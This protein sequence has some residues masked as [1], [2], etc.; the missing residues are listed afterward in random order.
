MKI[1]IVRG[2]LAAAGGA[3]RYTL[4]LLR[5]LLE[6]DHEVHV[7]TSRLPEEFAGRVQW[8]RFE[9]PRRLIR[10][11]RLWRQRAFEKWM[12]HERSSS[13]LDVWLTLER[14]WP[15]DI[16]RAGDGVH[17]EWL[18]ICRREAGRLRAMQMRWQPFH[19][20]VLASEARVFDARNTQVVVC[21]SQ[22]VAGEI[23]RHYA[24]PAQRVRVVPNGVDLQYFRP[25]AP[26][27]RQR[28]RQERGLQDGELAVLFVG[29]G[30]WRKGVDRALQLL[31]HWQ[32]H[33]TRRLKLWV[34]GKDH[35]QAYQ[36]QAAQLGIAGSV[37]W[38]GALPPSEVLSWYQAAD[39]FLFPTR[40][41]PFANVCLEANACGLPV[42]TTTRNGFAEQMQNGTNGLVL[43][44]AQSPAQQASCIA[45]WSR[46]LPP[47][48]TVRAAVEHLTVEAH[49]AALLETIEECRAQSTSRGNFAL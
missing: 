16:F 11:P 20:R 14:I 1:G 9:R 33:D 39:L 41:D 35:L 17:R 25:A 3:E 13:T 31:A 45:K 2:D 6:R 30:F 18:A 26:Q 47:V 42:I 5:K 4:N 40:Y 8:H 22:M 19:R 46:Q 23:A 28:L 24:F 43:D 10:P 15:S 37:T 27:E 34:V 29:S 48:E 21:N 12:R 38:A 49:T 36:Q 44:D 32:Q 7:F